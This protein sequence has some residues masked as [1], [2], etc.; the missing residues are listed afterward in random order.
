MS[1]DICL[2]ST[3]S[4][5]EVADAASHTSNLVTGTPRTPRSTAVPVLHAPVALASSDIVLAGALAGVWIAHRTG[6]LR[7]IAVTR[8]T[9]GGI[10]GAQVVESGLTR[11]A[12]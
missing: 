7:W 3:L 4:R 11:V 10:A 5:G 8:I 1:D 9:S 2:A 12:V 6:G